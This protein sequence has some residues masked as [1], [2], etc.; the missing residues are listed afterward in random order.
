MLTAAS[1]VRVKRG[2]TLNVHPRRMDQLKDVQMSCGRL[3]TCI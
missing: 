3:N 1:F 2:H